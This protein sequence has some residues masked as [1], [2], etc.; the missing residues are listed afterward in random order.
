MKNTLCGGRTGYG[1]RKPPQLRSIP[2]GMTDPYIFCMGPARSAGQSKAH[3]GG[4]PFSPARLPADNCKGTDVCR[5]LSYGCIFV[6]ILPQ[7][8]G[9]SS[10]IRLILGDRKSVV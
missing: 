5:N 4:R 3:F 10:K 7:K 9:L 8:A 1:F 6:L 2:L